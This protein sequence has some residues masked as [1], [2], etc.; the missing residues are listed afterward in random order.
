MVDKKTSA[1][2]E[3]QQDQAD[4]YREIIQNAYT[5]V[6][7]QKAVQTFA[8]LTPEDLMD[9]FVERVSGADTQA[10]PNTLNRYKKIKD[11]LLASIAKIKAMPPEAFRRPDSSKDVNTPRT[12]K[13]TAT[14]DFFNEDSLYAVDQKTT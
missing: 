6:E 4:Q 2:E 13:A 10:R 1:E 14:E 8:A 7:S 3:K 11:E 12:Y 5:F 9:R